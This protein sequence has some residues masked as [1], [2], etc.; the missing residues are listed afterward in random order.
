MSNLIP[1][2]LIR[3]QTLQKLSVW[4]FW[5]ADKPRPPKYGAADVQ[6]IQDWLIEHDIQINTGDSMT[7]EDLIQPEPGTLAY[8]WSRTW[9][10][11]RPW[12]GFLNNL[13][14]KLEPHLP[15]VPTTRQRRQKQTAP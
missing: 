9:D 1:Q 8:A 15:P 13:L 12:T 11:D 2:K 10:Q 14:V 4:L 6:V 3:L 5:P 7:L